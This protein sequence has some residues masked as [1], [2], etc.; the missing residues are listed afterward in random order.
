MF[1]KNK[2]YSI[3]LLFFYFPALPN[4]SALKLYAKKVS[5]VPLCH[6]G[7]GVFG[8]VPPDHLWL[9]GLF[10]FFAM[11]SLFICVNKEKKGVN[12]CTT[13]LKNRT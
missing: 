1:Q 4:A 6:M 9:V 10:L 11:K 13:E 8:G 5:T 7:W 2:I 3:L 12:F